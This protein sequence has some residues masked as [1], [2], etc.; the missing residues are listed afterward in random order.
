MDEH[1]GAIYK[2]R[3]ARKRYRCEHAG[4]ECPGHYPVCSGW[5]EPGERYMRVA[6]PPGDAEVGN[7]GWWSLRRHAADI[8]ATPAHAR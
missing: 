2:I 7:T 6:L 5:I 8:E 3:T 1:Y 4:Y